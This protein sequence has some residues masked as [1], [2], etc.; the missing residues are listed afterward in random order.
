MERTLVV[1]KPDAVQRGIVG[2]V[3]S[4]FEKVGLKIIGLKMLFPTDE[5]Y[6]HHYEKIGQMISRRGEEIFNITLQ[7]MRQGPVIAIVLEGVEAPS[8]VRKMVGDTEPRTA[9]PGTIRGDYSHMSYAH[10]D[11]EK[12][13]IPNII[14]ASSNSDEAKLE[15]EHW[16]SHEELYDYKVA[17]E[18]H[19]QPKGK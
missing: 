19:T 6:H 13:G 14:H 8:L 11:K 18:K 2:E 7:F 10:G 4:R 9:L 15:I 3:I 1:L 12:V 16:F 17:H 5:H